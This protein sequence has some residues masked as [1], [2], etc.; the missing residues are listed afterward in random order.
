MDLKN[1]LD[2]K[3]RNLYPALV[4]VVQIS[5]E[6]TTNF[7]NGIL[8]DNLRDESCYLQLYKQEETI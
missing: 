4:I 2:I 5:Q 1:H 6:T 7:L 3:Y 8:N